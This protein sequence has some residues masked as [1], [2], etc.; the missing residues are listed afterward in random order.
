M[1]TFEG[2]K[3]DFDSFLLIFGMGVIVG[4]I[5]GAVFF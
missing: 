5:I 1:K 4:A 2:H 3:K